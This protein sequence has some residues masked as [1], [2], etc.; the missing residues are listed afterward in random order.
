MILPLR[1]SKPWTPDWIAGV[2]AAA[3]KI[4][5]VWSTAAFRSQLTTALD[6]KLT[7]KETITRAKLYHDMFLTPTSS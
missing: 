3:R 2:C 4:E 7:D 1:Q 6:L 5:Q